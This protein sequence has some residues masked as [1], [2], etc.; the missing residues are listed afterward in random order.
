MKARTL[1]IMAGA[2][3]LVFSLSMGADAMMMGPPS[4]SSGGSGMGP[5]MDDDQEMGPRWSQ[6]TS[7]KRMEKGLL[8]RYGMDTPSSTIESEGTGSDIGVHLDGIGFKNN[9]RTMNIDID[10]EDWTVEQKDVENGLEITYSSQCEWR[11]NDQATG[12]MSQITVRFRYSAS[13]SER[14]LGYNISIDTLPGKGNLTFFLMSDTNGLNK[15][16]S[17]MGDNGQQVWERKKLILRSAEGDEL[18]TLDLSVPAMVDTDSGP[19]DVETELEGDLVNSSA[20]IDVGLSLPEG[21]TSASI[22]GSLTLFEEF[23]E[24]LS[25][26]LVEAAGFVIDHIYYFIGGAAVMTVIIIGAM[27]VV[28]SKKVD[29]GG[30]DLDLN[31]NKYYRGPQ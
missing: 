22:F 9:T 27:S 29:T 6:D 30:S 24:A 28:S 1:W 16:C 13:D 4:G 25:G 12:K 2:F 10:D 8:F 3:I 19:Q 20:S 31:R 26:G 14:M 11:E 5:G 15:G 21:A 18:S 7:M 17:W 23:V